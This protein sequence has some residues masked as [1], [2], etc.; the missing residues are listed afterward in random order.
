MESWLDST[1]YRGTQYDFS[2]T[3]KMR[4]TWFKMLIDAAKADGSSKEERILVCGQIRTLC[5]FFQCLKCKAHFAA[6][7][8]THAP[9]AWIDKRDGLFTWTVDFANSVSIAKGKPTYEMEVIYPMFHSSNHLTCDSGCDGTEEASDN[10]TS[11]TNR[12]VTGKIEIGGRD[13]RRHA[14]MTYG[15]GDSQYRRL[16]YEDSLGLGAR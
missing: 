14:N 6:R 5:E 3:S 2:D 15:E 1:K 4:G 8:S 11:A 7:L 12:P 9:E 16:P 13:S 10:S